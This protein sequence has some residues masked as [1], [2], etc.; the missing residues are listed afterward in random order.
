MSLVNASEQQRVADAIRAAETRTTGEIVAVIASESASYLS[1]PVVV[2]ACLALLVPWPLIYFTWITVQAI[3]LV[4]LGVFFVVLAALLPKA[5]RFRLVPRTILHQRAHARAVEQ[6]LVQGLDTSVGRTGVLIFVSVAEHYAEI[7]ADQGLRE[8]VEKKEWQAIV[9]EMVREI[10][11]ERPSE[12]LVTAIGT[13]GT[14]LERHFPG[15]ADN[16]KGLPDHLIV[17]D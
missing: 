15:G 12:A 4:Q 16:I 11:A 14:I 6:F 17:L 10:G 8:K 1:V 13:I 3:Y 9:D 7:I 2:A 5:V